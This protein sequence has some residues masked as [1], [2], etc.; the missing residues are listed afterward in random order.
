MQVVFNKLNELISSYKVLKIL[1]R[2][3]HD[4]FS[5]TL[6]LLLKPSK[7]INLN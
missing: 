4:T 3:L 7:S 2:K 1:M 6:F 5:Q